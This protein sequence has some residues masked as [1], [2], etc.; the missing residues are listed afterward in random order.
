MVNPRLIGYD[1][2]NTATL[3]TNLKKKRIFQ[4]EFEKKESGKLKSS[5]KLLELPVAE[6]PVQSEQAEPEQC[7]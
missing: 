7:K 5:K 2:E 6:L 3:M 1:T 4:F